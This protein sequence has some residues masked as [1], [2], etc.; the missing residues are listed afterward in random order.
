[1]GNMMWKRMWNTELLKNKLN[2]TVKNH[3]SRPS[4][5]YKLKIFMNS[6][7]RKEQRCPL[8]RSPNIFKKSQSK[9]IP[10]DIRTIASQWWVQNHPL[11]Y[12]ENRT[13]EEMNNFSD[14]SEI[15][16]REN[17]RD[18]D[19]MIDRL[20]FQAICSIRFELENSNFEQG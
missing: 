4:S 3:S 9:N 2:T 5:K 20:P 16:K 7:T 11:R 10:K 19:N 12:Y 1:M 18:Q 14:A 8:S 6:R 15:L 17:N 13:R